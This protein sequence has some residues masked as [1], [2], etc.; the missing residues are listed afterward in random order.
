MTDSHALNNLNQ[1]R[2]NGRV[3]QTNLA[4]CIA[5]VSRRLDLCSACACLCTRAC[6]RVC[7][8]ECVG[9][10]MCVCVCMCV[11]VCAS[12]ALHPY[13]VRG[14]EYHRRTGHPWRM[15]S[16]QSRCTA[17]RSRRGGKIKI[18]ICVV[19]VRCHLFA[20]D[21]QSC[22]PISARRYYD[23]VRPKPM[24]HTRDTPTC[25]V[26]KARHMHLLL[27]PIQ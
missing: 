23:S 14:P 19:W 4:R 5:D 24:W 26:K 25:P 17:Q 27:K 22:G 10:C 6:V 7:V 20:L 1:I 8:R 3:L 15:A 12:Q 13:C 2:M 18:R 16:W 21:V 11:R 9:V